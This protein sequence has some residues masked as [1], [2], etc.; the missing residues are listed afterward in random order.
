MPL[1]AFRMDIGNATEPDMADDREKEE[2][3]LWDWARAAGVSVEDLKKA[4]Q[5]LQGRGAWP[6]AV[7]VVEGK[8]SDARAAPVG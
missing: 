2:Y 8:P 5:V 3:E 7:G 6:A 1:A 4:L